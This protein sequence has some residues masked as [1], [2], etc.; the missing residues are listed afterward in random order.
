MIILKSPEEVRKIE[1]AGRIVAEVLQELKE[2]SQHR[3][4]SPTGNALIQAGLGDKDQAFAELA[5][6][7]KE[8]DRKLDF[9][10]VSPFLDCLRSDPRFE[11]LQRRVGLPM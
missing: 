6:A 2:L 5:K 8:R 7:F 1:K 4:I 10:K 9:L 3:Y 11:D